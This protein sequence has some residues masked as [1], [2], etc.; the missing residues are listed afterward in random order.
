MGGL[1]PPRLSPPDPKSGAATITP[2]PQNRTAK[3]H[4]FPKQYNGLQK[5]VH[6]HSNILLFFAS[7]PRKTE[8]TIRVK[9]TV[10][11]YDKRNLT[12]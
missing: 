8:W 12:F 10:F 3:I 6:N 9:Q 11:K 1:E 4:F 5:S 2:H 7:L